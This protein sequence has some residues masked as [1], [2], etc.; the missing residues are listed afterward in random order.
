MSSAGQ[1]S[2]A[3]NPVWDEGFPPL[4]VAL[5]VC[6]HR[7]SVSAAF[8]LVVAQG[9]AVIA[10]YAVGIAYIYWSSCDLGFF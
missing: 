1:D 9:G 4:S 10:A 6:G 3:G 7:V 8:V 2:F 5:A